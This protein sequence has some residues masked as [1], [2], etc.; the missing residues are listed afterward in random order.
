MNEV[1][2][3]SRYNVNKLESSSY[4]HSITMSIYKKYT[5]KDKPAYKKIFSKVKYLLLH[6]HISWVYF[7]NSLTA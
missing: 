2:V 4:Y 5:L 6:I 3:I 7:K 1:Y